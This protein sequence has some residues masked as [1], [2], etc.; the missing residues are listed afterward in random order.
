MSGDTMHDPKEQL[1]LLFIILAL[2]CALL[3]F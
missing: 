1:I 2:I 3:D